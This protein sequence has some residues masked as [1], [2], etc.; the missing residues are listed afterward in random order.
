MKCWSMDVDDVP[1]ANP[2]SGIG[3]RGAERGESYTRTY[4]DIVF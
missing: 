3:N 1:R 2:E 4:H